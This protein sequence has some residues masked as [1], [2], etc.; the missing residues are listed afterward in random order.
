[1]MDY[2]MMAVVAA[3]KKLASYVMEPFPNA[4]QHIGILTPIVQNVSVIA[5]ILVQTTWKKNAMERKSQS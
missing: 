3:S 5:I 4:S 2:V 1:M